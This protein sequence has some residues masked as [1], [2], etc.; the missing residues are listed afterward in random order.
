MRCQ[1]H[2]LSVVPPCMGA[3]FLVAFGSTFVGIGVNKSS[4]TLMLVLELETTYVFE[5]VIMFSIAEVFV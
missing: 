3:V 1:G 4:C 2:S 5:L